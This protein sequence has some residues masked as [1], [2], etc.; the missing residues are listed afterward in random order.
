VPQTSGTAVPPEEAT[1]PFEVTPE[2]LDSMAD[3]SERPTLRL[4]ARPPFADPEDEAI[5]RD[6]RVN[7][8]T[9]R[10]RVLVGPDGVARML[11]EDELEE[12]T[13]PF[14]PPSVL[15]GRGNASKAKRKKR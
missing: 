8:A 6:Q 5:A 3:E 9:V 10:K 14:V 12:A 7:D 11:D 15:L 1:M 2:L 4:P 13:R